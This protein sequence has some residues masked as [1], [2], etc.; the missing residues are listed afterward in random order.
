[1]KR[2]LQAANPF[3][4]LGVDVDATGPE[5]KR[6]FRRLARKYH[7]D[8]AGGDPVLATRFKELSDAYHTIRRLQM[9]GARLPSDT[10]SFRPAGSG[11]RA[12]ISGLFHGRE[13]ASAAAPS[14]GGDINH[15]LTLTF[16]QAAA[17]HV[18]D[19]NIPAKI[20]CDEC[21]GTGA[22]GAT[23]FAPCRHCRGK[24]HVGTPFGGPGAA[25]AFCPQCFGSGKAI[26]E[27]CRRCG[28]EGR[29]KGW[30]EVIAR[31]PAG[32]VTGSRFLL[33]GKGHAGALNWPSGDLV[34]TVCVAPHPRLERKGADIY[35]EARIPF[36]TAALGGLIEAETVGGMV[37]VRL[38]GGVKSPSLLRL[39]GRGVAGKGDH[40]L[41]VVVE[42]PSA[43]SGRDRALVDNFSHLGGGGVWYRA[44]RLFGLGR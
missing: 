22:R 37:K 26:V 11:L 34:I 2:G 29:V 4:T 27:T 6:A 23:A 19:I 31:I 43:A 40:Y 24:G 3:W 30:R 8:T 20:T 10:G 21:A 41:R 17:G 16:A 15:P 18:A 12:R 35:G 33:R 25:P 32:A 42:R 7:P 44:R 36:A 28:G 1:M 14:S 39:K 9:R 38:P 13:R 5:I